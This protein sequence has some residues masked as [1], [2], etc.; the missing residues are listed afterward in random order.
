KVLPGSPHGTF[1]TYTLR[2][3]PFIILLNAHNIKERLPRL[4]SWRIIRNHEQTGSVPYFGCYCSVRKRSASSRVGHPITDGFRGMWHGPE[5]RKELCG[6]N[7]G[8]RLCPS[9]NAHAP[10]PGIPHADGSNH[11]QDSPER[12][13]AS[14]APSGWQQGSISDG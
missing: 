12:R 13:Q 6:R 11:L 3:T 9:K 7:A 4:S 8:N 1:V 5:K 2:V 10:L 14:R